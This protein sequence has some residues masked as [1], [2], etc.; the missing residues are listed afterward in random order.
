MRKINYEI[1]DVADEVAQQEC[2]NNKC[3]FLG[4]YRI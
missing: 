3:Y 2:S 1:I 4:I